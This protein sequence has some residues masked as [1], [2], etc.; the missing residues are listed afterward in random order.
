MTA[1]KAAAKPAAND[2]STQVANPDLEQP[3]ADKAL[4]EVHAVHEEQRERWQ[5]HNR[6]EI[7]RDV[8]GI[9]DGEDTEGGVLRLRT[10]GGRL[11]VSCSAK[12]VVLDHN[13]VADLQRFAQSC[14]QAV[15]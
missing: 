10:V 15:S 2:E 11:H 14:F 7:E 8:Q 1:K 3:R 6:T 4:D 5:H 13:G 9:G 12:E